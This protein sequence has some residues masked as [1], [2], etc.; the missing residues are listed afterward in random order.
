VNREAFT[1]KL[2]TTLHLSVAERKALGDSPSADEVVAIVVDELLRHGF[3]P[4]KPWCEGEPC[5][6]GTVLE[7]RQDGS[8][9][10]QRQFSSPWMTPEHI[11]ESEFSDARSAAAHLVKEDFAGGIDGVRINFG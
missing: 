1:R 2:V 5:G 6:D 10:A 8:V 4:R 9:R 7:L 11:D 3:F